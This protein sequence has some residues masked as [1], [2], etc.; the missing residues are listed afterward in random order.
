MDPVVGQI[1]LSALN[2]AGLAIIGI[3]AERRGRSCPEDTP[4]SDCFLP[5]DRAVIRCTNR[6][7]SKVCRKLDIE[8]TEASDA[9]SIR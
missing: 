3:R 1:V 8:P 5:E 2:L 4:G 7:V 9:R 6:N